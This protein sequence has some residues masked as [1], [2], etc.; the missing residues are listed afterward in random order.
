MPPSPFQLDRFRPA[1]P[2]ESLAKLDEPL[3]DPDQLKCDIAYFCKKLGMS[4]GQFEEL[5]EAPVHHYSEFENQDRTYK[6]IK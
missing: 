2:R 5:M 4:R 6:T 1:D 3:Y